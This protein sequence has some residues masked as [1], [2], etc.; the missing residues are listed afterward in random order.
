VAKDAK[1][2]AK[3]KALHGQGKSERDIAGLTGATRP[4][5]KK[6]I[7]EW[8]A[9]GF[10]KG[11][12]Q[13]KLDQAQTDAALKAAHDAGLT[14][15]KVAAKVVALMDAQKTVYWQGSRIEETEDNGTQLGAASL[16]A[17]ILR[18]KGSKLDITSGGRS[19]LD[20]V[21]DEA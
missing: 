14:E 6:W 19:L 21:L 16:G 1:T 13:P 20:E 9:T 15:A 18:M 10:P 11:Y 2:K 17:D 3:A 12:L 8:E 5:V 7:D 4:T